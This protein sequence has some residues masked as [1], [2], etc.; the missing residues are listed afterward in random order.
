MANKISGKNGYVTVASGV[1]EGIKSWTMT[2]NLETIDTT[3]FAVSAPDA[4]DFEATLHNA[5]GSFEG[6]HTD[7]AVQLI[8][9]AKVALV[10]N[11]D[12]SKKYTISD[13][14]ITTLNPSV[15][16]DGEATISYSFQATVTPV[17]S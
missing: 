17:Y 2:D 1:V 16:V 6:N 13:A 9:G 11:V 5:T 8:A 3:A 15:A 12:S 10:L 14:I 7:G 4:R